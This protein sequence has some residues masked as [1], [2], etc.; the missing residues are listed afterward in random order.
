MHAGDHGHVGPGE[1]AEGDVDHLQVLGPRGARD[2]ARPG[3]DVVDDRILEPGHAKMQA[4]GVD[5]ILD[6]SKTREND[7]SVTSLNYSMNN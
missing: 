4:F 1:D 7:G 3:P 5:L 6:A 2:L